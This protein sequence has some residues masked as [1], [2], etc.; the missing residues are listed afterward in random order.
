MQREPVVSA[1]VVA[2]VIVTVAS[3]LGVVLDLSTVETV[4][5][6]VLIIVS[7][8]AAREKVSPV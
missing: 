7:A 4:I 6:D 8:L 3:L 5:T 2:S 1:A